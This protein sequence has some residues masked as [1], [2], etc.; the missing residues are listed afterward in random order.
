MKPTQACAKHFWRRIAAAL[1]VMFALWFAIVVRPPS[2]APHSPQVVNDVTQ[3]NPETVS[4]IL[5]PTSRTEI[6][7]AVSNHPGPISIGGARHSMGGQIATA[8]ALHIDMR[9]MNRIV[10]Y[11]PTNKSITVEAGATWRQVQSRIDPDGLSVQI[12]QTYANFTVGGSLSVNAH[13]RY[14]GKGP[15]VASVRAIT[16]VLAD[17]TLVSADREHHSE[18][19]CGA[20]GGYGGLGVIVDATLALDDNRRLRRENVAMPVHAYTNFFA[21]TLRHTPSVIFHN[22]D[23]YPKAYRT[24]HAVSFR[25]TEAPATERDRLIPD[26]RSYSLYR[27]LIWAT[28]EWPGGNRLR[29]HLFD[30]LVYRGNPVVWRNFEASYDAFELEPASRRRS[31][32]VLAE[33]FIPVDH[34]DA[35]VPELRRILQK[36][37]VKVF[38]ISI[39]H[40]HA[41]PDTLLAWA[42]TEVFAFVI[43]YKQGT[44]AA[45]RVAAGNWTRE[46]IDAALAAGGSYYLPYQVHATR[47]QFLAAYPRSP[48]FFALKKR[49]DPTNKF[50]NRLW[51]AYIPTVP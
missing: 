45:A 40:A 32:Y 22:A 24:V 19:F 18:L 20:I 36:H 44:A 10:A 49:V 9:E 4:A 51:D 28:T 21:Q 25:A 1:V 37:A 6:A 43:Y 5:V 47:E 12:M 41:D 31:T 14:L 46:L 38:N 39:R 7:M 15:I 23:L 42:P 27:L 17:G 29:Q 30:P 8:H 34:F 16:L 50:R 13:G 33:Y 2:P 48:A 11:S 26:S 35:F 3:L